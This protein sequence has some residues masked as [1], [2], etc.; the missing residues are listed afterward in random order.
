[1]AGRFGASSGLR[2]D[3]DRSLDA[4][5]QG[6]RL[7]G[8]LKHADGRLDMLADGRV[9]KGGDE[10][11]RDRVLAL[12]ERCEEFDPA[13]ARHLDIGYQA[14]GTPIARG[15]KEIFGRGEGR[16]VEAAGSQE[17]ARSTK[18]FDLVVDH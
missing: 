8:L 16:D 9:S 10:D 6:F 2:L 4:G 1:M 11:D 15:V 7:I 3:A 12:P 13:H 14:G 5:D 18:D 17:A